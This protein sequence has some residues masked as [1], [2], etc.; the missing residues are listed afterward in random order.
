MKCPGCGKS[1]WFARRFCP[2]CKATI[3]VPA[4]PRSVTVISWFSIVV[5]IIALLAIVSSSIPSGYGLPRPL[6]ARLHLYLPAVVVGL[7]GTAM[8][9][10]V[11]WARWL[12]AVWG[13]YNA[14]GQL[15]PFRP[16]LLLLG[17]PRALLLGIALYFLFRPAANAFFRQSP[18]V[19]PN[20]PG[21]G[22]AGCVECGGIF[23]TN[24]MFSHATRY[25][26]GSCKPRFLQ[27]LREGIL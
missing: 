23:E 25:V 14:V 2:F 11:N 12:F 27:K 1:L 8:L 4:R 6:A 17:L 22:R 16:Y 26:C 15:F 18:S 20:E 10:G 5:G 9:R 3:I 7:C 13:G 21:P 19:A 24:E